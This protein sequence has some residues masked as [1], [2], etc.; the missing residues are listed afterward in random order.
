MQFP[1]QQN[2]PLDSRQGDTPLQN[3]SQQTPLNPGAPSEPVSTPLAQQPLESQGIPG[4]QVPGGPGE[5][6]TPEQREELMRMLEETSQKM[7]ELQTAKFR[8]ENEREVARVETLKQIF[9]MMQESGVDL[10]DPASVASFIDRLRSTNQGMA[11][12]FEEA[13]TD[14]LGDDMPEGQQM[15]TAPTMG[16][17]AAPMPDMG[18]PMPGMTPPNETISQDIRGPVPGE[19]GAIPQ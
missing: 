1:S 2:T 11:A 10:N 3:N 15:G 13:L 16:A 9:I 18:A 4:G 19:A 8:S 12:Q 5:L 7:G 6:A 14:L 17:P